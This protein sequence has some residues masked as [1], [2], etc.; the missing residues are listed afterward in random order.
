MTATIGAKERAKQWSL[1]DC[2]LHDAHFAAVSQL[3]EVGREAAK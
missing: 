1:F 3:Y 2:Q